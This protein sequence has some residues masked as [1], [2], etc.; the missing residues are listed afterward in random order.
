MPIITDTKIINRW[1]SFYGRTKVNSFQYLNKSG[2]SNI[3]RINYLKSS[4]EELIPVLTKKGFI[5]EKLSLPGTYKV[6]K[7][8]ISLGASHEFLL[9]FY[10]IQGLASQYVSHVVDPK[11]DETILDMSAA[12][13][14]KTAHL[15]SLMNNSG[16]VVAIDSS[17]NRMTALRSNLARLG[18]SN[19]LAIQGDALDVTPK[20]GLFDKIL[21][22]APCSGSGSIC[23]RP[24]KQWTKD[25]SDIG[26]LAI[27]QKALLLTGL[28]NLKVGGE[29]TFS[30]CSL[31]PEEGELQIIS[32]LEKFG[33]KLSVLDISNKSNI[34]NPVILR[35]DK[36]SQDFFNQNKHK[37]LRI[38]PDSDYEGFFICKIRKNSELNN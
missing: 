30:T 24:E 5:L 19:V 1:T 2:I 22:D 15:S 14:G 25:E 35:L 38:I 34:F 3:I 16:L 13:G 7:N 21:L 37:W 4:D 33:K 6:V 26:R 32:L 9:G 17:K 11:E 27:K 12:P 31:E 10:S 28:K 36:D 8:R 18:V 23:K 29:L 20:L